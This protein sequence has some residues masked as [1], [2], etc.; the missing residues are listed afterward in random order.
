MSSFCR[1]DIIKLGTSK[2]NR[3]TEH[4]NKG[5]SSTVFAMDSSEDS[6][7]CKGK[8][9]TDHEPLEEDKGGQRRRWQSRLGAFHRRRML[10][11]VTD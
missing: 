5:F 1:N 11:G 3:H 8:K 2:Q 4:V 9:P 6:S 7:T 10:D